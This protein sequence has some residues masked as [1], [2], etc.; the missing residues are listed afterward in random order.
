MENDPIQ[1]NTQPTPAPTV[2]PAPTYAPAP[3]ESKKTSPWV[4]IIGGC[5]GIMIISL[6]IFVALGW[7]GVNKAKDEIKKRQPELEQFQKDF[8]DTAKN[9][10]EL[11]NKAQELQES[12]PNPEDLMYAMPEEEPVLN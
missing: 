2:N 4:W 10:Q 11:S 1:T 3:T 7:W 12:M 5:L 8:Q 6:I 9:A